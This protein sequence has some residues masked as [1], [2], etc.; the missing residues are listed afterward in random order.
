MNRKS[1]NQND[2]RKDGQR[3][4]R[5]LRQSDL[6]NIGLGE[7]L[8][9]ALSYLEKAKT[10][11]G[12]PNRIR[13]AEA[14]V[15]AIRGELRR[16]IED[17]AA[18][19]HQALRAQEKLSAKATSGALSPE[20]ANA[21]NKKIAEKIAELREDIGDLNAILAVKSAS[22]LGGF[23]DL[24]FQEYARV[25]APPPPRI[26]W[27]PSR[28]GFLLWLASLL[29]ALIG[30]LAYK[31]ALPI[32]APLTLEIASGESL[33]G[34]TAPLGV[35]C[36]NTSLR[37][38]TVYVPYPPEGLKK[39]KKN[40]EKPLYGLAV[41]IRT[42]EEKKYREIF[43][44]PQCWTR[45]G[46]PLMEATPIPLDPYGSAT[47]ILD[48]HKLGLPTAKLAAIRFALKNPNGRTIARREKE[49]EK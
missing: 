45:A 29:A 30:V 5:P 12:N 27:K 23:A 35:T 34:N 2:H 43:T 13:D 38:V 36:R 4:P 17:H 49:L 19:L 47:L 26:Q 14:Q 48:T 21:K 16:E 25:I 46:K 10:P 7:R 40:H 28:K 8:R 18:R 15:A 24:P 9:Y 22:E 3:P 32:G 39:I 6:E 20:K 42:E 1:G 37:P 33:P 44:L 41:Y 11:Q 31:G